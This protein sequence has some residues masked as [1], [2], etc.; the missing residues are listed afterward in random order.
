M[1]VQYLE[2]CVLL[3]VCGRL[4]SSDD[5]LTLGPDSRATLVCGGTVSD[6]LE[7]SLLLLDVELGCDVGG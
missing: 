5:I 7:T 1:V 4:V 3:Y 6:S 2:G